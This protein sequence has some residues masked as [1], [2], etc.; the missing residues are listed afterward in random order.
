MAAASSYSITSCKISRW[1]AVRLIFDGFWWDLWVGVSHGDGWPMYRQL[2]FLRYV[3]PLSQWALTIQLSDWNQPHVWHD[4]RDAAP[5]E[6]V[7][8]SVRE[9]VLQMKTMRLCP[10]IQLFVSLFPSDVQMFYEPANSYKAAAC[11]SCRGCQLWSSDRRAELVCCLCCCCCLEYIYCSTVLRNKFEVLYLS[12]S[13]WSCRGKYV[14]LFTTF[15]W[16]VL[17][18]ITFQTNIVHKNQNMYKIQQIESIN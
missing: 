7:C 8:V 18:V 11:C 15:I 2:R 17:L 5:Q 1:S 14:L 4:V 13:M 12:I 10:H 3:S 16:K 6:C 9:D